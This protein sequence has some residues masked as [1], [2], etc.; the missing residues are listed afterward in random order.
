M[1]INEN[2]KNRVQHVT[3][4]PTLPQVA[5]RLIQIINDPLTSSSDIA[6]IIGQ[7]IA[8]SSKVLRLA[9]SAFYG[10]PRTI[11]S[12][13]HAIVVLGF[14]V[15]N[16]MV[17]GLTVFDMFPESK[18][19][20][21]L[22]DRKA[23]W[24]HSLSCGL[25]SKYLTSK[26]KKFIMFDPEEAFC[27]GL[28]HDIGKVVM[29]QYMHEDFHKA[30]NL[31]YQKKIPLYEAE[32]QIFGFTHTHVAEWLTCG[33]SLPAEIQLPLIHHHN[34]IDDPLHLDIISLTHL[35][36]WICYQSGMIIN[37]NYAAPELDN[38]NVSHLMFTEN[39]IQEI[40]KILPEEIEKISLFFDIATGK[41]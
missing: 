37:K 19:N 22:F 13:N 24:L 8:L 18:K 5:S 21:A 41:M 32:N 39:D 1:Q 28:L 35:A 11:T 10:I 4:L 40:I 25:I 9:N 20:A 23:F 3:N 34:I 14:K 36:D 29:E 17:L 2:L 38:T 26:I 15:I 31:A 27:A 30:L 7:D 12:I 16:T 33:W 6:F